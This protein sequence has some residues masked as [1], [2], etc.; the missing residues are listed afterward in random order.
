[1]TTFSRI[2]EP[3]SIVHKNSYDQD[4]VNETVGDIQKYLFE[5]TRYIESELGNTAQ[6]CAIMAGG[7]GGGG[8]YFPGGF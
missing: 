4:D 7:G 6:V 2:P 5:L 1:M 3:P 8:F